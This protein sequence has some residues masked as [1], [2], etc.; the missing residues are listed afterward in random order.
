VSQAQAVIA[1]GTPAWRG[2]WLKVG[3]DHPA[4]R[5]IGVAELEPFAVDV[6]RHDD[7]VIVRPRYELDLATVETLRA[8]LD[9]VNGAARLV[10]DMRDLSFIESTGVHLLIELHQRARRE[11]FELSL[12]APA[13][14]GD[15]AI[16]VCGLD[17]VLPFVDAA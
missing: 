16:H 4:A 14:P 3:R 9:D 2:G 15:R 7:V 17:K 6:R 8:A 10:L 13:P 11:G 12:V 1:P 5:T